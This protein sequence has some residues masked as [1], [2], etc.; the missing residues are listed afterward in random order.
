MIKKNIGYLII[1]VLVLLIFLSCERKIVPASSA[2]QK[3]KKYD[4]AA[5][6]YVYVEA[7]KQKLMGNDGDALKYLEQCIKI[8]PEN[9]AAYYQ[10]AQILIAKGDIKNGK[11]FIK[12]ALKID[13][14]NI[15]YLMMMAGVYYQE[16][17]LDSAIIYYEKAV[18]YFPDR[19]NLQLT[20][21]NLYSENKNYE[22]AQSIFDV[23]D[24][25]YG[26]NENSTL[27]SVKSFLSA[28]KFDEALVKTKLL[29][30]EYPD[31]ILYNGL[32][33]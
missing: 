14:E 20:L 18:K 27:A 9:D 30:N 26:V 4:A 12:K 24:K 5:F 29:L 2:A 33:A 23:F 6:N 31:E 11:T 10:M 28:G 25:K 1:T 21:G 8:S 22:K 3:D 15:W 19:E 32:L 16:T 13:E 17:N 7:I